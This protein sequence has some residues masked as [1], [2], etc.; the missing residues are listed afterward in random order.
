MNHHHLSGM[1]SSQ[2][3][4]GIMQTNVGAGVV[5]PLHT[6]SNTVGSAN[7]THQYMHMMHMP[8]HH[9]LQQKAVEV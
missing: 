7:G 5:S 8:L 2:L 6:S 4:G 3:T 9:H 1:S